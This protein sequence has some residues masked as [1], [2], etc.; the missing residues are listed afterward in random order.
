MGISIVYQMF[1]GLLK[2]VVNEQTVYHISVGSFGSKY[3]NHFTPKNEAD[4]SRLEILVNGDLYFP[5]G[6][7]S[8]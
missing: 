5:N 4:L 7:V 1:R 6:K 2:C 3:W 8:R